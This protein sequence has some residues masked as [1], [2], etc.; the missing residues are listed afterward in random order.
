MVKVALKLIFE[1]TYAKMFAPKP[2]KKCSLQHYASIAYD[3]KYFCTDW[4]TTQSVR[5][6]RNKSLFGVMKMKS[7]FYSVKILY[8]K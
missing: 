2:R 1:L 5:C 7:L 8:K 6:T 4:K 3:F